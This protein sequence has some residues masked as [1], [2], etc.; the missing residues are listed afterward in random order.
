MKS[1]LCMKHVTTAAAG[2][3]LALCMSAASAAPV[4]HLNPA[5]G[6]PD[7]FDWAVDEEVWVF[8]DLTKPASEQTPSVVAPGS[9][10]QRM[11]SDFGPRYS[12]DT[13]QSGN[14]I[15][16]GGSWVSAAW[17]FEFGDTIPA[18]IDT[19]GVDFPPDWSLGALVSAP[20]GGIDGNFTAGAQQYVGLQLIL[21]GIV[22]HGWV[23]VESDGLA[24]HAFAWGYET[25]P[26]TPIAAGAGIPV[27]S[28]VG[29]LGVAGVASLRRRKRGVVS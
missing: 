15:Q 7:H 8:L 18:P 13:E 20:A 17:A 4:V 24:L 11:F 12:L 14:W 27:P 22:H 10:G 5:P 25:T 1:V 9:V 2:V 16:S 23:G 21:D 29:V 3:G 28:A 6:E 19:P 26:D